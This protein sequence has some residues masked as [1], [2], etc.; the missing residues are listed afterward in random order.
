M[1]DLDKIPTIADF[2]HPAFKQPKRVSNEMKQE[3]WSKVIGQWCLLVAVL[4]V[5]WFCAEIS[6]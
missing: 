6:R 3:P 4:L 2:D 5:Y 1:N